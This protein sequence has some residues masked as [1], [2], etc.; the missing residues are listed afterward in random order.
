ML[1]TALKA[2]E[3]KRDDLALSLSAAE[4]AGTAKS[5]SI[6]SL[7]EQLT[8]ATHRHSSLQVSRM[9]PACLHRNS[10][11]APNHQEVTALA[12]SHSDTTIED[13]RKQLDFIQKQ[14]A[15]RAAIE[16]A[17]SVQ[18]LTAAKAELASLKEAHSKLQVSIL[19]EAKF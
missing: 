7:E 6:R 18:E 15:D 11:I 8:A 3:A 4:T 9:C 16:S 17:T 1:K 13:L 10:P 12:K 2:V 5:E 19:I 14:Q